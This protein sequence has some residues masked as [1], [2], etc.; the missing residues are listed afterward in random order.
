MPKFSIPVALS[1]F[2]FTFVF[3]SFAHAA[4]FLVGAQ[5]YESDNTGADNDPGYQFSTN[6]G[7]TGHAFFPLTPPGGG[8]PVDQDIAFGL[9]PG[10]NTFTFFSDGF[11]RSTYG[12][13]LFFSD[14]ATPL[15]V[16][17]DLSNGGPNGVPGDLAVFTVANSL[18]FFV[19][20]A[21]T[22]VASYGTQNI[23]PDAG[24][25]PTSYSGDTEVIVGGLALTVTAFEADNGEGNPPNTT[26]DVSFTINAREVNGPPDP[27]GDA[28]PAPGMLLLLGMAVAG[29]G[30]VRRRIV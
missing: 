5:L 6:T 11:S 15:V 20:A 30:F 22:D 1:V 21:G 9:S 13:N 25:E 29:L 3:P 8:A 16:P 27:P 7:T 2:V 24:R 28:V 23:P 17:P 12:L 14:T 18:G 10:A 4:A 26:I 19:P